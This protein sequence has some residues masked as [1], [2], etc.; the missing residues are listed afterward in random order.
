M[1]KNYTIEFKEKIVRR[2]IDGETVSKISKSTNLSRSTIYNWLKVAQD[3]QNRK[4]KPLNLHLLNELNSKCKIQQE[5]ID[6]LQTSPCSAKA[7]LS[8]KYKVIEELS[9]I[10]NVNRLCQALKVAKGSY[11]NHILRSVNENTQNAKKRKELT[12]IIEEL[13]HKS[14]QTYGA[15]RIQ[16]LLQQRGYKVGTKTVS[17]IMHENGW[18]CIRGGSKALYEMNRQRKENILNQEFTVFAPN[19]VWVSDVTYFHFNNKTFYIC[20]ILD[21]YARKVVAYNISLKN[22]TQLTKST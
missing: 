20:V 8:E 9:G 3:N 12:P 22:S 15:S 21:L 2:F 19:E 1:R 7:P 4:T 17:K 11:Y 18:F 13:Y 5:I 14:K 10:Y 16:I 6:I